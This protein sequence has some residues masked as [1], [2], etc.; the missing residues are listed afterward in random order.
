MLKLRRY[1]LH[2]GSGSGIGTDDNSIQL[3]CNY[4]DSC[5]LDIC[6]H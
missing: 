1:I 6:I 3:G 5:P 2:S 4:G